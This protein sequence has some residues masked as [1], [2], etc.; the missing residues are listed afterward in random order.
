MCP[1]QVYSVSLISTKVIAD[2]N[3][4]CHEEKS[5]FDDTFFELNFRKQL[6]LWTISTY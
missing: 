1:Y 4:L 5:S 6:L 2:T 3:N